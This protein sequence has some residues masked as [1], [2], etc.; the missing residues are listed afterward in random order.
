MNRQ[1]FETKM[2]ALEADISAAMGDFEKKK[3]TQKQLNHVFDRAEAEGERLRSVY[4]THVKA[5][6]FGDTAASSKQAHA[7]QYVDPYTGATARGVFAGSK[8]KSVTP[9][10][11]GRQ[12]ARRDDALDIDDQTLFSMYTA[13]KH[14][15][16]FRAE[17]KSFSD[18]AGFKTTTSAPVLAGGVYPS[19]ILPP[20]LRSDLFQEYRFPGAV[21]P[22]SEYL[23][24]MMIQAPSIELPVQGSN[25]NPAAV[26]SEAGVKADIGVTLTKETFV[27]IKIAAL[28]S[29]SNE[30]LADWPVFQDW[31]P[32]LVSNAVRD[33][34]DS[35]ILS[36]TGSPG[37]TGL[38]NTSNTLT[39]AFNSVTDDTPLDTILQGFD[40]I[41]QQPNVLGDP[42]LV[43]LHP[44]T[45]GA[46]RREKSSTGAFLLNIMSPNEIGSLDDL[47]G[48]P[49]KT[50]V[51]VPQGQAII[52][53]TALAC[54]YL[55][56]QSLEI[57]ANPWGDTSWTQNL[58][59]FR[60][61][62]RSVIAVIRPG[63]INLLTGLSQSSDLGS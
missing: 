23:P 57:A 15:Q 50:S 62:L 16:P 22:V 28:G 61:E 52:M 43:L 46:I 37:M 44:Y 54:R 60:A 7:A 8:A 6:S 33:A 47:W 30:I 49:V 39:R 51:H 55:V 2:K 38:L 59:S 1:Q 56:R 25:T 27:P 24:T 42:D 18:S 14:G 5:R 21:T 4:A 36:G 29:A 10:D 41:R 32:R 20:E 34:E 13:L 17:C 12:I 11:G 9:P 3:I 26:V 58:V 35:Q 48:V 19:G 31:M 45:W 53:D 63:A 40:D